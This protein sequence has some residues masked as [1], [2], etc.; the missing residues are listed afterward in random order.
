MKPLL[1]T[2]T[3]SALVVGLLIM[4]IVLVFSAAIA[5]STR[6][7][8]R[9]AT[10]SK[11]QESSFETAV[12]GLET[13]REALRHTRFIGTGTSANP[14]P[15]LD[16]SAQL[17]TAAAGAA[18]V[19]SIAR[20]NFG[21]TTGFTKD[22][23]ATNNVPVSG[24][25]TL[26][27]GSFQV[28]LTN[29]STDGITSTTDTN[30]TITLTSFASGPNTIGFTVVQAVYQ[31]DPNL[32]TPLLPGL[33]TVPGRDIS[34]DLPNGNASD[35]NGSDGGSPPKCYAT[36]AVTTQ[37]A[38]TK[39]QNAMSRPNNYHTCNPSGGTWSGMNS[40]DNFI[41]GPNPYGDPTT[42][43]NLQ[44]GPTA[45]TSISYLNSLVASISASANYV[46]A[47][48]G[49]IN[50][51]TVTNPKV[52]VINGDFGMGGNANGAG[53][54]VVTG[55]LN[56]N[57]TPGYTGAI[58]VIGAGIV[59]RNGG[60]NGQINC[61]GM[62]IANTVVPDSTNSALVGTPTYAINGG[63]NSSFNECPGAG[64]GNLGK[65]SRSLKR[66][67]FQQLR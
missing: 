15:Y 30:D 38:R 31:S 47:D 36:I 55:T 62:L 45:L 56:M 46:G 64:G 48:T 54:L 35:M 63:G 65:F 50:L 22:T 39:V 33:L 53:I 14:Q 37:A 5:V 66:I 17:T 57:G 20:T 67:A 42:L 13:A 2:P 49:G 12:A 19:N 27:N 9:V 41:Q 1:R 16:F 26:E 51:G 11:N 43:P 8:E 34:V 40:V 44:T 21:T 3:G 18:L 60:G 29:D 25:T 32:N 7:G 28:F 6:G 4:M 52:V 23:S 61:G 58:Y 24:P 10:A 59:N